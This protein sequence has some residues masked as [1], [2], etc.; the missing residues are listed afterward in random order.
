MKK[1]AKG[2]VSMLTLFS[3]HIGWFSS[4]VLTAYICTSYLNDVYRCYVP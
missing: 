1:K 2:I 4:W 3:E